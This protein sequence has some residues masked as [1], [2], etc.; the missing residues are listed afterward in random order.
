MKRRCLP[1]LLASG[2]L[3]LLVFTTTWSRAATIVVTST[4]DNGPGTLRA[5]LAS[6]ANNDVITFSVGLP[7]TITLTS[8]ELLSFTNVTVNGPGAGNLSISGNNSG[9]VFHIGPSNIVNISGL[10]IR[11]ALALGGSI[12]G[13]I[14]LDNATLTLTNCT[15]TNNQVNSG[16]GG[17]IH[18]DRGTLTVNNCIV[19]NNTG[20]NGGGIFNNQATLIV[21]NSTLTGNSASNG[22]AIYNERGSA[23]ARCCTIYLNGAAKGAGI[24][25][26]AGNIA[27]TFSLNNCTVTGNTASGATGSGGGIYNTAI[28]AALTIS[29]STISGNIAAVGLGGGIYNTQGAI[30]LGNT[31]LKNADFE[32]GTLVNANAGIVTSAGYN[33]SS[34]AAGGLL[35][36]GGDQP[37]T[38]TLLDPAGLQDNGGPTLTIALQ[39]TSAAI[40]KGKRDTIAPLATTFDQRGE[41]RPFDD[42]TIPNAT[43]G[44]GSDI[45]AYEGGVRVVS[46]N[47][48]GS[49]LRLSFTTILSR[50]Y[51]VQS[52][53][54]L[55]AGDWATLPGTVS[56]NGG[57]VP[58][59]LTN[60]FSQ[61]RQF[62][63]LRQV[64]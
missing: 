63:R 1:I 35:N 14:Y 38:N 55:V 40:D 22:G 54:S 44:D 17:G 19:S 46:A 10:T 18:N 31:I 5:A 9:R 25:N 61:P 6:A 34:D 41:S 58:V 37:N 27:G 52:R 43:S 42:P 39:S 53:P 15:I 21:N 4:A 29:S 49:D 7:A 30:T 62:Y 12:G 32:G 3:L 56:G 59:T 57:I 60:A 8:G 20:A 48:L 50:T 51:Q 26:F 24:F 47:S 28:K 13:G 33:L 23:A 11:D 36:A 64:P 16:P 45:G 2:S